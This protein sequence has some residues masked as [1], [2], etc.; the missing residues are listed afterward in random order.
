[1][2]LPV[3]SSRH[4]IPTIGIDTCFRFGPWEPVRGVPFGKASSCL[5][6]NALRPPQVKSSAPMCCRT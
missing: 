5:R 3:S 1:M 2:H 6:L 4:P